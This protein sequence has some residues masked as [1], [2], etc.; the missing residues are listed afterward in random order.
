MKD[1]DDVA[2]I[3]SRIAQELVNGDIINL[4]IGI[5]TEVANYVPD[6]TE[7]VITSEN[8][9]I[10]LGKKPDKQDEH[11]DL[12]N[13]GGGKISELAETSYIDSCISFGIIRGGHLDISVLGALQVDQEGNIANW[14][15]PGKMTPGMGGA[16]D[17]C[18]GAKKIVA[19]LKHVDKAGNSKILKKCN[20]PLT[21][22][23]AVDLIVTDMAVIEITDKKAIL[24]E[25]AF[26]TNLDDV[27]KATEAE[28]IISNDLTTFGNRPLTKKAV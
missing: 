5:P 11:D 20:L 3:A 17:L 26:W 1:F 25:I 24:K 14:I 13:A 2:L 18:T 7:V 16:M 21:A 28:L 9:I 10:G 4:G 23:H 22:S 15:I 6:T 8:G 27:I 19:A 12:I